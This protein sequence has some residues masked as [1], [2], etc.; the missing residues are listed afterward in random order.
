MARI[1]EHR[2]L[3]LALE[4]QEANRKTAFAGLVYDKGKPEPKGTLDPS[5][6]DYDVNIARRLESL[7]E[8]YGISLADRGGVEKLLAVVLIEMLPAFKVKESKRRTR[9]PTRPQYVAER[10]ALLLR[11]AREKYVSEGLDRW[12]CSARKQYVFERLVSWRKAN[13][14][15]PI[16]EE[17]RA[18]DFFEAEFNALDSG[19]GIREK[20]EREA[21]HVESKQAES[22]R[23][24]D[25]F[26]SER[27]RT[28]AKLKKELAEELAAEANPGQSRITAEDKR[29][30][31]E[32]VRKELYRFR[33]KDKDYKNLEE[34][35]EVPLPTAREHQYGYHMLHY[36]SVVRV[37][38]LMME[39]LG[40]DIRTYEENDRE[41]SA[42]RKRVVWGHR[43]SS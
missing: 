3:Q 27:G 12:V 1:D 22:K 33:T 4:K 16:E 7:A 20:Q 5:A 38:R 25:Q 23:L 14:R 8:L 17:K 28:E 6:L 43:G 9:T 32:V 39:G 34:N 37:I 40:P 2:R 30:A 15:A 41:P 29:K 24:R 18:S 35:A 11:S 26:D 10:L 36:Q 13:K 21:D 42:P 31:W 19:T